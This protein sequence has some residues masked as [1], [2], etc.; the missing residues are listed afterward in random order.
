[1]YSCNQKTDE[2]AMLKNSETRSEVFKTIAES[3]DFMAEFMKSMQENNHAM[4][5]MPGNNK[6]MGSMMQGENDDER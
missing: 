6:M 5:M 2:N 3:P 4:Q 1:M